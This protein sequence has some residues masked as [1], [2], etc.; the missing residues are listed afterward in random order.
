MPNDNADGAVVQSE[1]VH[2]VSIKPP[3][4]METAVDGWFAVMDAQFH[5]ARITNSEIKFTMSSP[6]CLPQ[7]SRT[8]RVLL[9]A[10]RALK[11]SNKP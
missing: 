8:S 5:I 11:S 6:R 9:W 3:A 4:F 7:L 2:H 1:P 10:V